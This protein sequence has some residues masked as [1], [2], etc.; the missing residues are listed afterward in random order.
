MNRRSFIRLVG[1]ASVVMAAG[2]GGF[3]VTRRPD[4][5][6][7]PWQAAGDGYDDPRMW[8]LSYAI[9]APNPHNR[10][11]WIADLG[12]EGTVSLYCDLQR[13][14]PHTDPFSRQIV[15]GLGCFLEILRM[16]AAEI[17]YRADI[18]PFPEGMPDNALDRRPIARVVFEKDGTVDPDPL[19]RFVPAR[20]SNKEPFDTARRVSLE[21]LR[22]LAASSDHAGTGWTDDPDAVAALRDLSWRAMELEITTP[23]TYQESIDLMRIGKAEIEANPDGIDIGDPLLEA[24]YRTGLMTREGMADHGS[25]EFRAGL[26]MFRPIMGTGM[27]Y[28]WLATAG[29]SR[30]D[31][32]TAGRSWVRLNLKGA[33]LGLG[34]H[35]ISQ[36]LQEYPEM[37]DLYAELHRRLG[38]DGRVQMLGR[39]GYG[40]PQ[41]ESPRWPVETI[42]RQG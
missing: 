11:P 5:A 30:E 16:A 12:E 19:F 32:L 10:Q 28:M 9:L 14:L 38:V 23:R 2:A 7:E 22:A 36:A 34:V 42:T 15:I 13:L 27:A 39:L 40:E 1:S 17:G 31:Q 21:T 41:R 29:N 8:T 24:L 37:T 18:R 20:R 26:D 35:P 3:V 6:L 25:Q 4:K 33:E